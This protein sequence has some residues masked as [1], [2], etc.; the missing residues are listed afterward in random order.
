MTKI[1]EY[2][3]ISEYRFH[4]IGDELWV[5][6]A[7]ELGFAVGEWPDKFAVVPVVGTAIIFRKVRELQR[8]DG[9]RYEGQDH[10]RGLVIEILND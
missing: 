4:Q 8:E 1:S 7:S 3:L 6:D 10:G 9:W 5:A 2:R